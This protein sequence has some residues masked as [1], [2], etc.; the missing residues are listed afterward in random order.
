MDIKQAKQ[1]K[2]GDVVRCPAD[3]GAAPFTGK[4][5]S[6]G[7][8]VSKSIHGEEYV[9]INVKGPSGHSA[10]VWPSNRLA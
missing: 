6:V 7:A 1:L 2:V 5:S 9:W 8:N 3:R 4:V 10:G